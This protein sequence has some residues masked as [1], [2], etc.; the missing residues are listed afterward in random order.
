[1]AVIPSEGAGGDDMEHPSD[2][3]R[4]ALIQLNDAL[5]T[6]ERA[7]NRQSMLI[8]REEGGFVQRSASGKP[9]PDSM[10][11]ISDADLLGTFF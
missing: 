2:E 10:S 6:W 7:T 5:C 1:M 4:Q 8:L 11:D 3:V 9:L